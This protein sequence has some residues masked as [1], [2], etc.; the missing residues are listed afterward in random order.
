LICILSVFYATPLVYSLN[1]INNYKLGP[2]YI[3]Y[4]VS[5]GV[6]FLLIVATFINAIRK[7]VPSQKVQARFI[8]TGF[9]VMVILALL[10]NAI[11]PA[12]ITTTDTSKFGPLFS[13]IFTGAIAYAIVKHGLFDIRPIV[14]RSTAYLLS[15]GVLFGAYVVVSSL[16]LKIL[17]GDQKDDSRLILINS[18]T[19]TLSVLA[20]QPLKRFFDRVTNQ[21]F[22]RDAYDPQSF[23]DEL[24]KVLATTYEFDSLL[25]KSAN[26]IDKYLKPTNATFITQ[27]AK[28][29]AS[30]IVSTKY[31]SATYVKA[32]FA[33]ALSSL[34][35]KIILTSLIG[36]NHKNL[37]DVFEANEAVLI[38]NLGASTSKGAN[39]LVLGPKKS[40]NPYTREDVR[41]VQIIANE[42]IIAIQNALRFKE[43]QNFNLTLQEKIHS[44]T[45]QLRRSNE[46]LKALDETKD[47]FISM[48]SHQ[49][50]T[51]LTSIKG[52]LSMLREGDAGNLTK[53]EKEMISQAYTSS[54]RMVYLISDMLN[55]SRLNTGKFVIEE[56]EVNLA[57]A[58]SEEV[59]QLKE[60]AESKGLTLSYEKPTDFP[61]LILD[62]TKM[63]QVI[64]NFMDNAIYYTPSGGHIEV[65]LENLPTRVDLKIVDDGIGVPK[66][67][68]HHLF[69]K[70]YRANN[71]RKARPDGT[72]LGLYMAK[73]VVIAQGGSIIFDSR[74]GKGSTFGFSF[75]KSKVKL[76]IPSADK[77]TKTAGTH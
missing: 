54:Q 45:Q 28:T 74:E 46:K 10:T 57:E 23:L 47:D 19:L 43:I 69:S 56:N 37:K 24:N 48:A 33:K 52:Y 49:L 31:S 38:V 12:I 15:I 66:N 76:H 16:F 14:A 75:H 41:I 34:N 20:Y 50:R 5:M 21:I 60:T 36:S 70:F 4:L 73:K 63:R 1:S 71:A 65:K 64:M 55:V 58:I 30:V 22:Y 61:V 6:V 44:A 40:G 53:L 59:E 39:F 77:N 27:S 13:V 35:E 9:G 67:E 68:K 3:P 11:I 62:E 26:I 8:L 51:P 2:L 32:D 7:G 72:G 29:K 18:A 17:L 25:S 42:L